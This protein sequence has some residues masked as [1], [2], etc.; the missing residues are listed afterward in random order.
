MLISLFNCFIKIIT[1]LLENR[2]QTVILQL[3]HINQYG[4]LKSRTIQ[5]CLAWAF[6]YLHQCN[7]SKEEILILKLDFEKAFKL[8]STKQF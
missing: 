7:Q 1:K 6:E 4:Y 5:E 2:L 3:V 8:Q